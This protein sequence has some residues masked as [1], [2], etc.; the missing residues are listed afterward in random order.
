MAPKDVKFRASKIRESGDLVNDAVNLWSNA[1]FTLDSAVLPA[2]CFGKVG[3]ELGL[4]DEY[5]RSRAKTI[6]ELNDGTNILIQNRE[7]VYKAA[8]RYEGAEIKAT[9]NVKDIPRH[10]PDLDNDHSDYESKYGWARN[11]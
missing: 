6:L 10:R 1:P 8:D 2:N 3:E 9:Q 4:R 11:S 7:A 5:E